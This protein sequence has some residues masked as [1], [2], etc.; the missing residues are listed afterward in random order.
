MKKSGEWLGL[1]IIVGHWILQLANE[2]I[3]PFQ[4]QTQLSILLAQGDQLSFGAVRVW[5]TQSMHKLTKNLYKFCRLVNRPL[6]GF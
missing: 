5:N 3:L 4:L 1:T 2:F 6:L